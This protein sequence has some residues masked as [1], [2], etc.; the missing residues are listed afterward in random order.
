[1][2]G[3]TQNIVLIR[4]RADSTPDADG[5]TEY[6]LESEVY[7]GWIGPPTT[8]QDSYAAAMGM[9]VDA[10]GIIATSDIMA[11]DLVRVTDREYEV[12][13]TTNILPTLTRILLTRR[14]PQGSTDG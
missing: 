14:E 13:R 10:A 1:M 2:A 4:R 8:Q 9:V 12:V 3:L 7:P 11:G 6:T 5:E